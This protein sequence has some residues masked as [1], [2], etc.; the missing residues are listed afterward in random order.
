MKKMLVV[1]GL[2]YGGLLLSGCA[3]SQRINKHSALFETYPGEAQKDIRKGQVEVGFTSDMVLMA[4]G[5]PDRKYFRQTKDGEVLVWTYVA[6]ETR[7]DKQK[8]SGTFR[9]MTRNRQYETVKDEVIADVDR[10]Y[11]YDRLRVEILN[12]QVVAVEE[13][14]SAPVFF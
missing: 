10:Y 11:E 14:K 4:L 2:I 6:R 12:D 3:T 13:I 8:V 9:V 7:P 5:R 1:V